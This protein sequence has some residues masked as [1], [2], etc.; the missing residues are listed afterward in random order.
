MHRFI[1]LVLFWTLAGL[2]PPALAD[3][4]QLQ[5]PLGEW[6]W[7]DAWPAVDRLESVDGTDRMV[8]LHAGV[9]LRYARDGF[10]FGAEARHRV[11]DLGSAPAEADLDDHRLMARFDF[12]L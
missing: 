12:D 10:A 1:P 2:A 8:R 5:V 3:D 6:V 7:V 11:G 4:L 9:G